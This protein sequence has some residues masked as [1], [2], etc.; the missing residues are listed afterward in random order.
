MNHAVQALKHPYFSAAPAA[1]PVEELPRPPPLE[2]QLEE[3]KEQE[4]AEKR[5][6]TDVCAHRCYPAANH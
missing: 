2:K 6:K 3:E 4:R 5:L 1:T